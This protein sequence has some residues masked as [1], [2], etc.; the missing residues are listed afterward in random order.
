MTRSARSITDGRGHGTAERL[1]GLEVH[2]QLEPGWLFHGQ[3]GGPRALEESI[4]VDRQVLPLGGEVRAVAHE[5]A[6]VRELR[7]A[8]M[9]GIRR[10][11]A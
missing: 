4:R 8:P 11:M 5:R 7:P 6:S 2:D 1:G 10:R 9:D 3:V